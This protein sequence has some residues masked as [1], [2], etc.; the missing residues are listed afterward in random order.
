[1]R[2]PDWAGRTFPGRD[3]ERGEKM[4]GVAFGWYTGSAGVR[5]WGQEALEVETAAAFRMKFL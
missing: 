4:E 5:C 3:E 1:M 2:G